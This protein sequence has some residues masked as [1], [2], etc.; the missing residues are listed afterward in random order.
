MLK[1]SQ[2]LNK[3]LH[4]GTFLTLAGHRITEL[5]AHHRQLSHRLIQ[6]RLRN[7]GSLI[8]FDG[9]P[10][11]GFCLPEEPERSIFNPLELSLH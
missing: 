5:L 11:C 1:P 4:L 3:R 6:L 9:R 8:R 10:V 7:R 2:G